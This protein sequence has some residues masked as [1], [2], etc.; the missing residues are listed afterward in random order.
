MINKISDKDKKDWEDFLK[1]KEKIPDRN[2]AEKKKIISKKNIKISD[3][4]KQDWEDF[5]KNKEKIP[6][7]DFGG[8]KN[9][10][11]EKIKKIDLHGYT[12]EEANKE[13]EKF[14]Q[15]CFDE[16]V[17]KIIV[18]TGK[19]LRSKNI[20]NPYLS[21]DMS[22]LKYSVPEFIEHNTSLMKVIIETTDARIEDGG[23]GAFY[24]YL[25]NKNKF[26]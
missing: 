11:H 23:S 3:K 16:S 17:T 8:K 5:L 9:I 15:K 6:N 7:K 10:R 1:N 25:K 24:I 20:E 14:I 18:I 12:I 2:F 26:K 13:V 21:R 22:I 4:D 19:G